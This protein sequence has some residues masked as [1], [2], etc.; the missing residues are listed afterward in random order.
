M[1]RAYFKCASCGDDVEVRGT[2]RNDADKK[3]AWKA[4]QAE[5]CQSCWQDEQKQQH[6]QAAE[7]NKATGLPELTGSP[8]QI[9]WAEGIRHQKIAHLNEWAKTVETTD[10]RFALAIENVRNQSAA[11]W[12]IDNRD[13]NIRYLVEK[14]SKNMEPPAPPAVQQAAKE[15]E[16]EAKAEATILP[17]NARTATVAEIRVVNDTVN[18]YFPEKRDDFREIVK[19]RHFQWKTQYWQRQLNTLNGSAVDRAAEMGHRLLSAG[20]GI[21]IFDESL[22]AKAI[23][24]DYEA[25]R[26]RWILSRTNG[27][28]RDHFVLCWYRPN[29][30]Y[31]AAMRIHGAR[32]DSPHV[33][34]PASQFDEVT[35]FAERYD[36]AFSEGA[37]RIVTEQKA[38]LQ[39]AKRVSVA[40]IVEPEAIKGQNKPGVLTAPD[41]VE[42]DHDLLDSD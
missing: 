4:K 20:F 15:G 19:A 18:I 13:N 37:Q 30:L 21:R 10:Q 26:T 12:W 9:L 25:E 33:V 3:A 14:I 27:P 41:Q 5:L 36:F 29:D 22:R 28:Y 23:S 40:P 24:G 7:T 32:Y 17:H 6:G 2:N 42:V 8:A 11:R 39:G 34:V 16:A 1:A 35:D 31:K 38:L